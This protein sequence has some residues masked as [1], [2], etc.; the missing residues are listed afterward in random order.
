[1]NVNEQEKENKT[2]AG[3][4]STRDLIKELGL[5]TTGTDFESDVQYINIIGSIEAHSTLPA[6]NKATKYEHLIPQLIAVEENPKLK[7]L[8]VILNTVGGDVEAGLALA[9]MI[10]TLS[11]PTVSL[12]LGG[13]HSIGIPLAVATDYS[14]IAGTATMT[15]HPIRTTGLVITSE[16]TFD[17]MR[18]TQ[19]RVV[20]FIEAHSSARRERVI[21]LMNCND[22]ISND[23]GTIL[24][25]KEAVEAGIIDEVGGLSHA[26]GELRRRIGE[27][28]TER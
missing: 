12:V 14:F 9:E 22:N 3:E 27:A 15:L 19:E 26:I 7:G 28:Q 4:D 21:E 10:S 1:M 13:G 11:K 25:G 17:Y 5:L 6:D 18:K 8:L 2:A 23:V 16:T 20:D 24:F